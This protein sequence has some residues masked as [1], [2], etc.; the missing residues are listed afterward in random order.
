[1]RIAAL[2]LAVLALAACGSNDSG[3]ADASG[4][5]AAPTGGSIKTIQIS[6]TDY[7]LSPATIQLDEPGFYTFHFVNDGGVIHALEVE[8]NGLETE[9][10]ELAPGKSADLQV[11]ITEAGEYELYCPVGGHRGLGMEGTLTVGGGAGTS[12]TDG[13]TTEDGAG[14]LGY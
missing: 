9:T 1:M 12:G 11:Q 14:S 2:A 4:I 7:K 8:G 6:A 3:G 5:S 13:T 10:E